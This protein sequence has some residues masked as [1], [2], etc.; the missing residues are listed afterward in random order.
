MSETIDFTCARIRDWARQR[1]LIDGSTAHA[2]MVKLVEEMGELAAAIARNDD[3]LFEDAIGDCGV[4]LTILAAQRHMDFATC[5]ENAY[6]EIKDRKG[7]MMDGVF[8][9]EGK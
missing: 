9:K 6:E 1:N 4:V 3:R 8:V 5:L 7:R 2:Q